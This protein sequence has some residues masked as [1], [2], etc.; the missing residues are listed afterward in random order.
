MDT[1][2]TSICYGTDMLGYKLPPRSSAVEYS[3]PRSTLDY[4]NTL[5]KGDIKDRDT[6]GKIREILKEKQGMFSDFSGK[7]TVHFSH[8][9]RECRLET[10]MESIANLVQDHYDEDL[11]E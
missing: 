3:V 7:G 4:L 2:G 9:D 11:S 8:M 6:L 1:K 10:A 5:L